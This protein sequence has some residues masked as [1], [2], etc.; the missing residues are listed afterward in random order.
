MPISDDVLAETP[1]YR[2]PADSPEIK[3]LLERRKE[4]GG[5]LPQ[6]RVNKVALDVPK[7]DYF[8]N[9]LKSSTTEISTTTAF[10]SAIRLA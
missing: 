9:F 8:E 1:F 6:R 3:Y 7:L 5:F 4:L 10:V 2:P